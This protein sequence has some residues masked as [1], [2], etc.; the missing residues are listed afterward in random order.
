MTFDVLWTSY[1]DLAEFDP[2]GAGCL[3]VRKAN[4]KWRT[5]VDYR[6]LNTRSFQD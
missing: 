6:A 1:T 3:L 2:Y 5:C 4:E